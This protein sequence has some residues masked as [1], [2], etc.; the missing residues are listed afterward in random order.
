MEN[1][2]TISD[3]LLQHSGIRKANVV[4][5]FYPMKS[6]PDITPFLQLLA[7]EGRLLLPRCGKDC[8]MEFFKV[9]NLYSDLSSGAYG[10]KEPNAE[11]KS[12][13]G[14]IPVFLVPGV[15]F[16]KKGGRKGHGKGY[17]DRY[18]AKFPDSL[19]IGVCNAE[20]LQEESLDLEDHDILMNEIIS[21]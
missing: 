17:Y 1:K 5:A 7:R 12:W 14:N 18:L 15:K 20:Q 9:T 3:L 2:K 8:S 19:K 10:I 11:C 4:A 6:E 21:V 16:D 13:V